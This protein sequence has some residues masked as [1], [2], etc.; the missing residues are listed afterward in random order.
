MRPVPFSLDRK[1]QSEREPPY[2]TDF[3]KLSG[4]DGNDEIIYWTA[5]F[6]IIHDREVHIK[7]PISEDDNII[8]DIHERK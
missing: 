5:L 6:S 8:I 7:A 4:N 3:L 2:S 1:S